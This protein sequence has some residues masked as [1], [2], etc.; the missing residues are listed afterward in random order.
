MERRLDQALPPDSLQNVH[1]AAIGIPNSLSGTLAHRLVRARFLW[2]A[3]SIVTS[4]RSETRYTRFSVRNK[5]GFCSGLRTTWWLT[6]ESMRSYSFTPEP[7]FRFI[8]LAIHDVKQANA[9]L[10][11]K[12]C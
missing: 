6:K 9:R 7:T 10:L 4:S 3:R 1:A 2:E 5:S 11:F 8:F 12:L